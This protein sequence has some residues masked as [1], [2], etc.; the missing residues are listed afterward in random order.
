MRTFFVQVDQIV[1]IGHTL[2]I[3]AT[4]IDAAGV[5]LLATGQIMG[6]PDD[7]E[8]IHAAYELTKGKT[9]HFGPHVAIALSEIADR[10]AVLAIFALPNMEIT[11]VQHPK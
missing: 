3:T 7:G 11:T 5:R 4:D 2:T 10:V 9:I 6:G 1:Q 8:T